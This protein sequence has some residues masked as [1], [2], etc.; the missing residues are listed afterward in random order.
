MGTNY[1]LSTQKP[2]S[3]CGR[4]YDRLHI[5]KSSGGWCFALHVMPDDGINGLDDWQRLWS[6][7]GATI[8]DEYGTEIG[9]VEMLSRITMRDGAKD[10]DG[11]WWRPWYRSE[12]EF[13]DRNSS[14][15]GPRGL[16]RH[17]I[18][19]HCIAHGDGTWD[20]IVGEFS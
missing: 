6:Q 20:C 8:R 15:R 12:Q 10:W 13:H 18:G 17:R 11:E 19:P 3:H 5:G 9:K 14:E 1:Y 16:L 4:E 2:C 7:P